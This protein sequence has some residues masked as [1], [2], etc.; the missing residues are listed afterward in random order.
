[1]S[2]KPVAILRSSLQQTRKNP[3]KVAEA[4]KVKPEPETGQH[5]RDVKLHHTSQI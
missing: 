1:M 4:E 5:V 2:V 3:R